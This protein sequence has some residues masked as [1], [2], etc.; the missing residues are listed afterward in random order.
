MAAT[1]NQIHRYGTQAQYDALETKNSNYLY[2]TSDTHKLYK[3][4]VDYTDNLI[5]ISA[6]PASGV[7]GKI[8]FETSTGQ[9]KA[10]IGGAWET[11][12]YPIS[13]AINGDNASTSA[14]PS[15]QAVVDYVESVVGDQSVVVDIDQ[16]MNGST[17]VAGTLVATMADASTFDINMAGLAVN[18]TWNSETRQ[19]VL[20]VTKTDGTTEN[21]TVD[22]GKDIF[23]SS[24]YYDSDTK[25]IVLVLNDDPED[26][27]EIR[28]PASALYNDY[29]G[30]DTATASVSIDGTTHEITVDA[31]VDSAAGNA[32]TV[33]NGEG[34]GLRVDLSA[35]ATTA[36]VEAIRSNLQGQIDA[37]TATLSATTAAL[38]TLTD[39]YNATT[40]ELSTLEDN[41]NATTA[42]LN[43][44]TENYNATTVELGTL[45]DNYNATTAA[46][47]TLTS[48]YN[49]TTLALDT[50][51][52]NYNATT[53][54]VAD[55]AANIT[56]LATAATTWAGFTD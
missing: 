12:S 7:A 39:N 49:N 41:Y 21:V 42:A 35:Y 32:I 28:V 30:G 56:A 6:V 47:D 4:T 10:Y 17:A 36:S 25:D 52:S 40:V 43:T 27:T 5:T 3:G 1:Y 46:L 44:L 37:T 53:V 48:N 13:Q 29:T 50:L 9:V 55:N 26:P 11:I 15:E 31:K 8:Y 20:P 24:G 34:G 23:L 14:V 2:F 22:I 18:P 54:Q 45:E 38:G 16:K 19:L 51:T 33:V